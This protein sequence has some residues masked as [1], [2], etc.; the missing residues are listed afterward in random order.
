MN[1][2]P[3]FKYVGRLKKPRR[4]SK[5]GT[6]NGLGISRRESRNAGTN[7]KRSRMKIPLKKI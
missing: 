1:G 7:W 6:K 4:N 3:L 2:T 5:D